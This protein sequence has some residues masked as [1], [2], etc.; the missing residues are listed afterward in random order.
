MN[1]PLFQR[2]LKK[3]RKLAFLCTTSVEQWLINFSATIL[4]SPERFRKI[5]F[6]LLHRQPDLTVIM[7]NVNK[8]HNLSAI[9]RSCDGVGIN[10]IHAVSY[11]KYIHTEQHAAAGA[12]KWL[13][14]NLYTDLPAAY[15]KVSE[16]G[17]QILVATGKEGALD[18]REIDYTIPT[19]LV[20]GAEWDGISEEAIEGA[21][22]AIT[23]PMLGMVE[24]LNVSV[25][26]A[27]ILFE[28]QRQR[29]EKGMYKNPRL[30]PA[31]FDRMLF[32]YAYPRLSRELQEKEN[33]YPQL[34]AEGGIC[35]P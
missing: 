9:I 22:H 6:M 12:S 7:D 28:A 35:P 2:Q 25:A 24:S 31:S 14:M 5:R 15:R 30:D 10:E 13:T 11:R 19:A 1:I 27:V 21:D 17:M 26:T 20:V 3:E 29:T 34:D 33:P 18:F 4:I 16:S 32:E 8:A 23:V